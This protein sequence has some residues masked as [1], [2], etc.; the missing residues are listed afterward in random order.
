MINLTS[1]KE[2]FKHL[3]E[4]VERLQNERDYYKGKYNEALNEIYK[5]KLVKEFKE[6]CDK[7]KTSL[8]RGFGI[9]EK[10][11]EEILKWM[12]KH[13]QKCRGHYK[14]IFTPTSLGV[15]GDVV[16]NVCGEKFNFQE[17]G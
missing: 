3:E 10:E 8:R 2:V 9:S 15:A 14:Y 7:A 17:I 16:C 5:D 6:E 13:N 4:L 11:H 12:K 1:P